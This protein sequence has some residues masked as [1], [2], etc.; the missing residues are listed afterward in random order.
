MRLDGAIYPE[1]YNLKK[2]GKEKKKK[3]VTLERSV[4]ESI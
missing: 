3:S 4:A 2:E 1:S